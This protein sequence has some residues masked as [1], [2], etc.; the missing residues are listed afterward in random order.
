MCFAQE[1]AGETGFFSVAENFNFDEYWLAA[2]KL[3]TKHTVQYLNPCEI[4][5]IFRFFRKRQTEMP[6]IPKEKIHMSVVG[7]DQ[8]NHRCAK[9]SFFG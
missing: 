9:F 1:R 4:V 5:N 6:I 3:Y 8:E 2:Q 7:I